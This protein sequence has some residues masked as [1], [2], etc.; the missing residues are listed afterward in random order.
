MPFATV[1]GSSVSIFQNSSEFLWTKSKCPPLQ[2]KWSDRSP[3]WLVYHWITTLDRTHFGSRKGKINSLPKIDCLETFCRGTFDNKSYSL[4]N[5][6]V[7]VIF[8]SA[9]AFLVEQIVSALQNVLEILFF[10]NSTKFMIERDTLHGCQFSPLKGSTHFE[11]CVLVANV[12]IF[13]FTFWTNW[14]INTR[15]VTNRTIHNKPS[16][17]WTGKKA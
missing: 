4:L 10:L 1:G 3:L 11:P 9:A 16:L 14:T 12:I 7:F 15:D 6:K 5:D 8:T 17:K 2:V 13:F